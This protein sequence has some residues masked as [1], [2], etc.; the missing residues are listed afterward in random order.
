MLALTGFYLKNCAERVPR[1][2]KE[3]R[4]LMENVAAFADSIYN[5]KHKDAAAALNKIVDAG[6]ESGAI[7]PVTRKTK[8]EFQIDHPAA[9]QAPKKR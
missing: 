5:G 2:S 9:A 7:D 4:E 1:D 6:I 8:P 3:T